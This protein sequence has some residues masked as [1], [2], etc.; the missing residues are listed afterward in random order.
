M[1]PV[2][3]FADIPNA[4]N[5]GAQSTASTSACLPLPLLP[6]L[7]PEG[8]EDF[9]CRILL[10]LS[11]N[12]DFLPNHIYHVKKSWKIHILISFGDEQLFP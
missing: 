8:Q 3:T 5:A 2:Q 1:F 9:S 4:G 6:A 12:Q 11:G 10:V 7:N